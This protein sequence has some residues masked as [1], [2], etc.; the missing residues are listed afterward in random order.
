MKSNETRRDSVA[1]EKSD[2]SGALAAVGALMAERRRFEGWISALNARRASTPQPVFDRVHLDYTNRLNTVIDQLTSHADELRRA[3]EALTARLAELSTEQQRTEDERAEA[4]LRAHVGELSSADWEQTSAASDASIAALASRRTDT[5]T[6]LA[7][8]R[9]LLDSTARPP[10]AEAPSVAATVSAPPAPAPRV[11]KAVSAEGA[12]APT[13]A[14]PVAPPRVSTQVKAAPAEASL[15]AELP[16]AVIAAAQQLLDIKERS[17]ASAPAASVE[18]PAVPT[19]PPVQRRTTGFDELA[20][21]SSVVDTPAGTF[22]AGPSDQPDEKARRDTFA[23]RSQEDSIMNLGA[24]TTPMDVPSIGREGEPPATSGGRGTSAIG[25][26]TSGDG[27][28]SL[29]C[30]ECGALN[31]PTE[32]YCERCGAELASL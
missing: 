20:F 29:K 32:W 14:V 17:S 4:E 15:P 22:D 2:P 27:V 21:L 8:M 9:E 19:S 26:D 23:M 1:T 31:Y 10:A 25:R 13:A 12:P 7:R 18:A 24:R 11:S 6:E 5:E 16:P 30:G 28:K 3:M